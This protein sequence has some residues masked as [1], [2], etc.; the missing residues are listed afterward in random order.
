MRRTALFICLLVIPVFGLQAFA[1][2]LSLGLSAQYEMLNDSG[3]WRNV[4][5]H[6]ELHYFDS[7]WVQGIG[8]DTSSEIWAEPYF[9]HLV[10]RDLGNGDDKGEAWPRYAIEPVPGRSDDQLGDVQ[11]NQTPTFVY[12]TQ[13]PDLVDSTNWSV[14]W[15]MVADARITLRNCGHWGI[16]YIADGRTWERMCGLSADTLYQWQ[17]RMMQVCWWPA[18]RARR[19]CGSRASGSSCRSGRSQRRSRVGP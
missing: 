16:Y 2:N 11:T 5:L 3:P 17:C 9:D 10:I 7:F 15:D 1:D 12:D 6:L 8:L 4:V 14:N 19:S 13:N 18:T